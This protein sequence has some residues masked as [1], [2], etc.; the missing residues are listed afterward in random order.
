MV[1]KVIAHSL[2][3]RKVRTRNEAGTIQEF[4]KYGKRKLTE[5]ATENNRLISK[6]IW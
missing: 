2:Y 4:L 3:E 5:S 6:M 1:N